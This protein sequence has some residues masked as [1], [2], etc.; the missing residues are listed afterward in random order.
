MGI[1]PQQ[2]FTWR[3]QLL[4]AATATGDDGFLAVAVAEPPA[5]PGP[6]PVPCEAGRIEIVLPSGIVIRVG[7]DVAVEP[8]RRVLA[9]LA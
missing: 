8:L 6:A 4:A 7:T 2:L 1:A 9:V 5:L 3:R